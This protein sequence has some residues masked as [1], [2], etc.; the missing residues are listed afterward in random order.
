MDDLEHGTQI[1]LQPFIPIQH[2]L[3]IPTEM[4]TRTARAQFLALCWSFFLLGWINGSTGPLLFSIQKTYGV[5]VPN[6]FF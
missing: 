1:E 3:K 6:F 5:S 4:E 2:D